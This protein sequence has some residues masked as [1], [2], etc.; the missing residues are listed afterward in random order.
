MFTGTFSCFDSD[1]SVADKQLER[2]RTIAYTALTPQAHHS[3]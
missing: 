3:V 1:T 2:S